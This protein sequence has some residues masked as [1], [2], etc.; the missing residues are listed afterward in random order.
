MNTN[1][2]FLDYLI[3]SV[4]ALVILGVGLFVSRTKKGQK[5]LLRITFWPVNLCLGGP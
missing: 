2:S 4:Y 5:K 3:F 1:F